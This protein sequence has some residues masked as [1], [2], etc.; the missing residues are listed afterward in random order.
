M[1]NQDDAALDL[2]MVRRKF[3]PAFQG[4]AH[5]AKLLQQ[6]GP[7]RG[8]IGPKETGRLWTR[9]LINSAVLEPF[10]PSAGLVIDLGSGAGLPGLVLA[11]QRPDLS[12][13]LIDA[14]R[15]RTDWLTEAAALL[16][17][18]NVVVT[19]SRAENLAGQRQAE[20][21]VSRAV[22]S[23]A[24][25]CA[26]SMPLLTAGGRFLAL[27]GRSAA[28]EMAQLQ[29]SDRR[30]DLADLS[31]IEIEPWPNLEPTFVISGHHPDADVGAVPHNCGVT[32]CEQ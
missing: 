6:E 29:A 5:L 12:F 20:A 16:G 1:T 28:T 25:L 22:G 7:K 3:G 32:R 18:T 31:V 26:W 23:L 4:L 21:V 9:H 14:M 24:D 8:L 17:L 13:E 19:W 10:L 2:A 15:R 27:K 30:V 11:I